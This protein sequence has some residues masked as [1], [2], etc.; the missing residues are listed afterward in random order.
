MS[1][2]IIQIVAYDNLCFIFNISTSYFHKFSFHYFEYYLVTKLPLLFVHASSFFLKKNMSE[3]TTLK[4]FIAKA[5]SAK[6]I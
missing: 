1:S 4:F 3:K 2:E 5:E 6:L